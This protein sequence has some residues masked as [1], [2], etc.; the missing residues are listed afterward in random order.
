MSFVHRR[1]HDKRKEV[2]GNLGG[3]LSLPPHLRRGE[4]GGWKGRAPLVLRP[5]GAVRPEAG[6]AGACQPGGAPAPPSAPT[7]GAGPQP[8]PALADATFGARAPPR[9]SRA[10]PTTA[11]RR[12]P[13]LPPPSR[14][15][16]RSH[17]SDTA[18][19]TPRRRRGGGERPPRGAQVRSGRRHAGG[20][21]GRRRVASG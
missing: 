16:R 14:R 15:G 8:P 20:G 5:T 11:L 12:S 17:R 19:D 3:H 6:A 13:D 1:L 4:Q 10:K 9:R 21:P 7:C 18:P 2:F